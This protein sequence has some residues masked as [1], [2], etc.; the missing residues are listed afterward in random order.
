MSDTTASVDTRRASEEAHSEQKAIEV[1]FPITEVSQLAER[2]SYRK[3]IF[4]PIYHIHKWWANRL[5]SVFRAIVLGALSEPKADVWEDFYKKHNFHNKVVLDPFMG[6]GTTLGETVKLG[7]KAIGCDIN[8]V[9]TFAVRQALTKV[10]IN[11]LKSAYNQLEK[12]AQPDIARYHTTLDPET[13]EQIPV[14]YYFWVKEVEAVG[15][16]I[17]LFSSYIFSKNAY[18]SRKPKAYIICPTCWEINSGR[19]D[20]KKLTCCQCGVVFNPQKGPV[21]GQYITDKQGTRYKVKD[22]LPS[23]GSLPRHR[24]YAMMALRTNGE[25]IYLAPQAYDFE[26]LEEA[27][28]RLKYEDLPLPT[29]SL[30]QGHNTDQ[31]RSYNYVKWRDFFNDRQLLCLGLLL[32]QILEV[33][34]ESI[35]DQLLCL[36]SSTL[37]FNNM[38]CSFKGEGTGAVRPI[39]S[40]HIL[41]PERAPLENSIWGTSKSS[42]TF[43]SLFKSR[44]LKAKVY[45]DEPTEVH[46]QRDIFGNP[47]GSKSTY[48]KASESIDVS[49][50]DSWNALNA[51]PDQVL[52]LN[53][54]SACLPIPDKCIHAVVTDP[55]YFDFVHY[56]ELSDFFF[57]WL[58][59]VVSDRY[60][61]FNRPNSYHQGEVQNKDPAEF[62]VRLGQV[63]RECHRVLKDDGVL[64]FSFHHSRP[65]GWVAIY[66]VLHDSKMSVASIYPV[67]AEMSVASPKSNTKEPISLDILL[68]CKKRLQFN[69]IEN[70]A[71][72]VANF[73]SDKLRKSGAQVSRNDIFNIKASALL[74]SYLGAKLTPKEYSKRVQ[75]FA[76]QVKEQ[77]DET[78]T[79]DSQH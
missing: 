40:H 55:P 12:N 18:P 56:S 78:D 8:P 67:H 27:R 43:S 72:E 45:L 24:L 29:L 66:Q 13:G 62:A 38:F 57:A 48:I 32:R 17:P 2:E 73:Y 22:L 16:V 47:D 79:L 70:S 65:E 1:S 10:S 3:E 21:S 77:R 39:F 20:A 74:A 41:K 30:R 4:R 69:D 36:F 59:P 60:P 37:E 31:A 6:S 71:D 76:K 15:E 33:E 50:A 7:A 52:V 49:L 19:Y 54:D 64:V 46:L 53:G 5:G 68:V 63:F 14:L 58:A 44:L 51:K 42:G 25:K 26:L 75:E 28:Q 61:F 34:E 35:K 11:D 23:D 9:S